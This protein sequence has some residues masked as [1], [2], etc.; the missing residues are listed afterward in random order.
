M[1][2]FSN[3]LGQKNCWPCWITTFQQLAVCTPLKL[4]VVTFHLEFDL[5]VLCGLGCCLRLLLG[6][7]SIFNLLLMG[8]A[9]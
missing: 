9:L 6:T 3:V 1:D 5:E 8:L 2:L 7:F 4:S